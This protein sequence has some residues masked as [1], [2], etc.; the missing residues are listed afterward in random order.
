[1]TK[2]CQQEDAPLAPKY[3]AKDHHIIERVKPSHNL[4][5]IA[6]RF[7]GAN[8]IEDEASG[9]SDRL[10]NLEGRETSTGDQKKK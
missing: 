10:A 9:A 5:E 8:G 2:P 3:G 1:M 6:S 4:E 7:H